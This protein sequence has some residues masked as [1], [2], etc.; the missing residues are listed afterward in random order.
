MY[1]DYGGPEPMTLPSVADDGF[2]GLMVTKASQHPY[3]TS[4]N[5]CAAERYKREIY[6]EKSGVG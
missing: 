2:I 1:I 3:S 5:F 6:R 4:R